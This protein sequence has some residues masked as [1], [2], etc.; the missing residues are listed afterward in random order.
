MA[1]ARLELESEHGSITISV[2]SVVDVAIYIKRYNN[3]ID[4]TERLPK[5]LCVVK[6][7]SLSVSLFISSS[8]QSKGIAET[9]TRNRLN[10]SGR[11]HS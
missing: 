8:G 4:R 10:K 3:W 11:V 9:E 7:V 1:Q 5:D 6:F 2:T